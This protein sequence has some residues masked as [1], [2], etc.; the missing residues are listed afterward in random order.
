MTV[1][2]LVPEGKCGCQASH[3]T[4]GIK[5]VSVGML[6]RTSST[7]SSPAA[8][9][10]MAAARKAVVLDWARLRASTGEAHA[11]AVA[12]LLVQAGQLQPECVSPPTRA[13]V[14][15]T[16]AE[17][18]CGWSC[19]LAEIPWLLERLGAPRVGAASTSALREALCI[20]YC[21]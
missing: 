7:P 3:V 11:P 8:A 2:V 4:E 6:L 13:G 17:A 19:A 21:E 14:L 12:A 10:A 20:S 5:S 1:V 16:C 9:A 15:L 18:A